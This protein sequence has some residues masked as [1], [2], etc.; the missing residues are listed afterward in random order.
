M[1]VTELIGSLEN[2]EPDLT[3]VV[4]TAGGVVQDEVGDVFLHN[5]KE[6]QKQR[7]WAYV[8]TGEQIVIIAD[9]KHDK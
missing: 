6:R 7:P 5:V 4:G 1:K 9:C 3:V 8:E 2:F